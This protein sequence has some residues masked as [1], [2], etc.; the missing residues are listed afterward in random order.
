[1]GGREP[2]LASSDG[3][4]GVSCS[5]ANV[6]GESYNTSRFTAVRHD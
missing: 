5:G 4:Q 1:M 3:W 2:N 6:W